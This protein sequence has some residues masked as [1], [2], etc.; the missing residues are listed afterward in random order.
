M[1]LR[2][3]KPKNVKFGLSKDDSCEFE[4]SSFPY[5]E[6]NSFSSARDYWQHMCRTSSPEPSRDVSILCRNCVQMSQSWVFVNIVVCLW[7][8]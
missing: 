4:E 2:E 6:G 5:E 1:A 3:R 8:L 7:N